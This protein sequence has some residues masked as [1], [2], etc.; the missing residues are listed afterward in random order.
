MMY[1]GL[2]PSELAQRLRSPS[3]L[4]LVKVTSTLDVIH[5]L[6][7]EGAPTGTVVLADEQVAGRGRQGRV[8]HSPPGTGIWL[9]YLLQSKRG[10]PSGVISLRVGLSI[11]EALAELGVHPQLK[12]PNDVLVHGRKLAGILCEARWSGEQL[13]WMGIGI[14]LNVHGP[15]PDEVADSAI[16]L[17]QVC[18]GVS[19]VAV[20]ERLVPKL[21]RLDSRPRLSNAEREAFN[22]LDCMTGQTVSRPVA[23]TVEGVDADGALL[24][25]TGQGT[26][27]VVGGGL[28]TA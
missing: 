10:L 23:G 1:D 9:G 7:A 20:L 12:W 24:V 16:V 6:A 26:E 5:Q 19:R 14:G 17:D 13:R 15:L 8:W 18:P 3:C 11:V 28:V 2:E 27:R 4:T 21:H 22:R 25:E